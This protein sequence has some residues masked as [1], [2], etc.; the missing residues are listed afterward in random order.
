MDKKLLNNRRAGYFLP[1]IQNT[2]SIKQNL[3]L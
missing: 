2:Y 1:N 3:N